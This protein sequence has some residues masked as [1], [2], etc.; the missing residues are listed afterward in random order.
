M[1]H[2]KRNVR[3]IVRETGDARDRGT[4]NDLANEGHAVAL[5][6]IDD[7]S[8]INTQ[9]HFFE[10]TM[11]GDWNSEDTRV[12]EEKSDYADECD[13]APRIEL[14]AGRDVATQD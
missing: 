7:A 1:A 6:R 10:R 2:G 14:S 9:V 5:L 8:D 11:S 12:R 4:R 13:P 3:L